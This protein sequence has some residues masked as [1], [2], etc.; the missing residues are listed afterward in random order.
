M[1][2]RSVETQLRRFWECSLVPV[3]AWDRYRRGAVPLLGLV[4]LLLFLCWDAAAQP[5]PGVLSGPQGDGEPVILRAESLEFYR[6]EQRLVATGLVVVESGEMRMFADRLDM[7]TDTG[8]GIALG[9]VRLVTPEDDVRASQLEFNLSEDRG[10]LYEAKGTVG[11]VYQISG[12]R[13]ERRGP[14]R[15]N[16]RRGR[17]TACRQSRPDW[18]FRT[19][20]A[21]IGVGNYV[22]L[23][24]PSFW[25]KGVPVFYLPYFV[26]PIKEERT[27]GFLPPNFGYSDNDGAVVR[28]SFFWAMTDWM[29]ST[30]GLEYLSERGW[31]PDVEFRYSLD[32]LSRGRLE[33]AYIDDRKDNEELW[34]VLIQQQQEFGWN[35]RG[36]T[37]IDLRSE[38]DLVRRFS[39]DILR[40]SQVRTVSFGTL[41][42][43]FPNSVLSV[44]GA[45]S[46]GIPEGGT[47]QQFRRLPTL[48][49][50]QFLTP[51]L[52]PARFGLEASYDRLKATDVVDGDTVQRLDLFP[53]ITLPLSM[54]SWLQLT[55]TAGLRETLYDRRTTDSDEVTRE[56]P[57]VRVHM[58]GPAWRRRF[59]GGKPN[60]A[61]THV[62]STAL[63]YRYVPRVS[64]GDLP[65]FET[66]DEAVHLLDPIEAMPLIDRVRA[67]NYARLS[68]EHRLFAQGIAWAG[69]GQVTEVA[70]LVLSQGLDIEEASERHGDLLGPLDVDIEGFFFSRW[71]LRSMLRVDTA[72]GEMAAASTILSV[73]PVPN[74]RV[75]VAHNYRQEPDVQYVN[76]G[77]NTTLF[78]Q[79]LR[80]G[81]NMRFDGLSGVV[82][83]HNVSLQYTG[84]CWQVE[85][86]F[87]IRNTENTPFFSD[88]SFT[89]QVRL[90]NF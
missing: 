56:L 65:G 32:P 74:W 55:L 39:R 50:E 38:R 59:A 28:S 15:L 64:Q 41:T 84:P 47:M 26:L 35:L 52:G 40:E 60:Q 1:V 76:G 34:R 62:M 54:A 11:G 73:R 90:F 23:N 7:K 68:F 44:L 16:V 87:R 30:L 89:I 53:Y 19:G 77:V 27:T 22:T 8:E 25:I 43:R 24:N 5:L 51:L 6:S 21:R 83:G 61:W 63:D 67:A 13:V 49:F 85:A 36:L 86:S 29:D 70:R 82:R 18:E 2:R 66:L 10:I 75:F 4:G 42:K 48:S 31:K 3:S 14:K 71:R 20:K 81:Y 79:R 78:D 57:D 69:G 9:N 88:T 45:S 58:A 72:T 33:A 12:Q 37:Q 46:D 17:I 80:L